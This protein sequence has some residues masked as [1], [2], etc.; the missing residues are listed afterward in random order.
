MADVE[1]EINRMGDS[2]VAPAAQSE[3][4][5]SSVFGGEKKEKIEEA[6][7]MLLNAVAFEG[8]VL[9]NQRSASRLRN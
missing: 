8:M 1:D 7:P 5:G 6:P 9:H 2:E 3:T 4:L